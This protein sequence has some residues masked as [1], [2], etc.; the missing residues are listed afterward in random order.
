MI[1]ARWS[2]IFRD[3]P[4]RRPG[5]PTAPAYYFS[6]IQELPTAALTGCMDDDPIRATVFVGAVDWSVYSS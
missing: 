5:S 1:R 6:S 2:Q 3:S 4:R